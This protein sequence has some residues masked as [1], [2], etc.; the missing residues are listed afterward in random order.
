MELLH[1]DTFQIARRFAQAGQSYDEHGVIQKKIAHRLMELIAEYDAA[2]ES[3]VQNPD[4]AHDQKR[5]FEIGCGSGN[6][7]KLLI[8]NQSFE[9]LYLNDL[10][11][12]V[13]KHFDADQLENEQVNTQEMKA[14]EMKAHDAI[15]WRMGDAEVIEFP[16]ELNLIISSSAM[17]WM[18]DLDGLFGKSNQALLNH[19]LLCF[20]TFGE[21]NLKEIKA[22]T[23]KG[24]VYCNL[25]DIQ[26]KLEQQGFEVLYISEQVSVLNFKHPKHVLQHLKATGVTATA[27]K[28]R[29]TKQSLD[30]FYQGYRQFIS[31][32]EHENLV[33]PLSYHP[34]YVIARKQAQ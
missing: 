34:I 10:Y 12:E 18:H 28:F 9:K 5:V 21:N 4:Q 7:T 20:S 31:T 1:I 26:Q 22:L 33:Y 30:N 17:Q 2:D 11:P 25:A 23:K 6:L 14:Q 16:Q 8:K 3:K 27:A 29:W 13:K 15:E 19:G 24:L 32:D